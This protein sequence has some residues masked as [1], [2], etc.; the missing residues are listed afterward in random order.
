[1][2]ITIKK[3]LDLPMTGSPEQ[4]IEEGPH[5]GRVAVIGGDFIGMKPTMLVAEGD[6]VKRGQPLFE[7]KKN[8][9]V[10]Y[11]APAAGEVEAINRGAR[12]VLQSVVIRVEGDDAA[13]FT[14]FDDA[15]I[16]AGLDSAAVREQL[17][18]SGLWVSLR[19]RPYS[20][21]PAVDASPAALFVTSIDSNAGAADPAVVIA[22]DPEAYQRGLKVL[23]ALVDCKI[24][25]CKRAGAAIDVPQLPNLEVAEFRG[26]HPSGLVGTHI[27]N[28]EPV[29]AD[30]VVWH[31][32]YQDVMAV[33]RLFAQGQ[34]DTQR[35]IALSGP[36]VTRPR[37]LRTVLGA[38][39]DELIAGE[40]DTSTEVRVLSG[41]VLS[42]RR[43]AGWGRYLSRYH[44]Q[45]TVL[46]EGREREFMGWVA[47]GTDKF[48]ANN[49]FVSALRRARQTF[50]FSTSQNGSPRAMVPIGNYERVMPLDVLP[51]QL[52]RALLVKDTDT[53]QAL[54]CLELDEEDLALC[55]FVCVGKY[56]YGPY[57]R[58]N[59]E[60]IEKEG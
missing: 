26:P 55:S 10:L 30:R 42:G 56:D 24:W 14:A 8:P 44:N 7:D 50:A 39:T 13:E 25:V 60:Q 4:R 16:D 37:L 40:I 48:S 38:C 12:R 53:A 59:L 46:R 47:P 9:G 5:I 17:I 45:I 52:L 1:M 22:D 6:R 57:L 41:A 21:V 32:N 33:G 2:Q 27:H 54:G 35:V 31:I 3:G 51:T 58:A 11:A 23:R 20:K 34:L 28:L 29:S 36:E 43:A 18:A 19:T 49:V 15:Q